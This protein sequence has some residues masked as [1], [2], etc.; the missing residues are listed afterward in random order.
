MQ[1][2]EHEVQ[3]TVITVKDIA[4]NYPNGNSRGDIRHKKRSFKE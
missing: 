1:T 2:S 3:H 4:K